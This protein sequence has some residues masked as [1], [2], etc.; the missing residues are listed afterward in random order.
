[1]KYAGEASRQAA[2]ENSGLIPISLRLSQPSVPTLLPLH[3]CTLVEWLT[4][5][6]WKI[7][8]WKKILWK[9][10]KKLSQQKK[11]GMCQLTA[12]P[13]HPGWLKNLYF[14]LKSSNDWLM[15][16]VLDMYVCARSTW[17]QP[18]QKFM[19][20]WPKLSVTVRAMVDQNQ[21]KLYSPEADSL[22]GRPEPDYIL[23]RLL[24]QL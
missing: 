18:K 15:K 11:T 1:M 14:L 2:Y 20:Y 7:I 24:E 19:C 16:M 9:I 22:Y 10:W 21:F 17:R 8:L 3:Q 6:M 5:P 23:V 4:G 13:L 12:E